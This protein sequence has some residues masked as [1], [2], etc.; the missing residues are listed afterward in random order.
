MPEAE[1]NLA[2]QI[3]QTAASIPAPLRAAALEKT[4]TYISGLADMARLV[5]TAEKEEAPHE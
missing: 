3:Q 1:K 2:K 5:A 4:S